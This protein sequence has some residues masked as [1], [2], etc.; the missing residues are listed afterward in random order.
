MLGFFVLMWAIFNL[1]SL[2]AALPINLIYIE[3]SGF[4]KLAFALIAACYFATPDGKM[5][6]ATA[7]QKA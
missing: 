2:L 4:V 1:F 3:I 7:C 5:A 6:E